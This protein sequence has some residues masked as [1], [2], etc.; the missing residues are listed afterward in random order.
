[1]TGLGQLLERLFH[2]VGRALFED[3]LRLGD[4][5]IDGLGLSLWQFVATLV[6]EL[7]GRVNQSIELVSGVDL[8]SFL[9]VVSGV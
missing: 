3:L 4:R 8:L 9:F 2:L 6:D 1:M 7:L 5:L